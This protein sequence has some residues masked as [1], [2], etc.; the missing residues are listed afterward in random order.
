MR[1]A[2]SNIAWA[3]GEIADAL[4]AME[5]FGARGL[6]IAPRLAFPAEPDPFM[7][8]RPA[9]SAFVRLV[10]SHNIEIVSMQSLMFGVSGA[11]LFGNN[12]ERAAFFSGVS[13]AIGL[14]QILSIPN[15]VMGSP[16]NRV[17]PDELLREHAWTQAIEIFRRLADIALKANTKIALEPNPAAYGTNFLTTV[18]ESVRFCRL[19]D[20]PAVTVNFDIGS[21]HMNH[22]FDQAAI[23]FEDAKS[24]VSHVH[25]SEPQLAPAPHN[26]DM[27]RTTALAFLSAGYEGWMSIEMRRSESMP[28]QVVRRSLSLCSSILSDLSADL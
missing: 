15:I 12:D 1:L 21:L 18:G 5:E 28:L 23:L 16:A 6:E 8:S 24:I 14:A 17:I 11:K 2:I 22:E 4:F 10:H 7:P 20:H 19:V 3:P 27:F 25:I 26:A 13:R 9:V